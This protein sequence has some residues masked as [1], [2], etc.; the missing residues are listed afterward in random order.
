MNINRTYLIFTGVFLCICLLICG[1]IWYSLGELYASREEYDQLTQQS[2]S[3]SG[4]IANLE[5]RNASL[6]KISD[7]SINNA[8]TVPDAVVFFSMVRQIMENNNISLLSMST[9][10]QNNSGRKD[11]VL[12]LKI[13]GNYYALARMFADLRNLQAPSKI[14]RLDLRRNHTLPE[15]LIDVDMTLQV[16]TEE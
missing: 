11:D 7:L 16:M 9:S 13:N 2:N 4:I 8:T 5:D 10:G 6:S 14:T 1:V 15:E 12:H 3:H